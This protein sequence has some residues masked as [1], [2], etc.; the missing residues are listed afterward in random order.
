MTTAHKDLPALPEGWP[1]NEMINAGFNAGMIGSI[2]S[3][4]KAM[5][6]AAPTIGTVELADCGTCGAQVSVPVNYFAALARQEPASKTYGP[7]NPPRLRA[8]GESVRDYRVSMGW[9]EWERASVPTVEI[10]VVDMLLEIARLAY[11]A[12]DGTEENDNGLQWARGDFEALSSAMDKLEQLP[13]DQPGIVM[14][15]AAKAAWALRKTAQAAPQGQQSAG[16]GDE[17]CAICGL[18]CSPGNCVFGPEDDPAQEAGALSGHEQGIVADLEAMAKK[19]D[20]GFWPQALAI[21]ALVIIK[22]KTTPAQPAVD[23]VAAIHN[24]IL[25]RVYTP[26]TGYQEAFIQGHHRGYDTAR[27]DFANLVAAHLKAGE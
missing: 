15:P 2:A 4:F 14:G 19:A 8:P 20:N 5:L 25:E 7:D 22:R 26:I 1:T 3:G 13:D 10:L 24:A 16:A 23:L 18:P 11:D 21:G 6:L 17:H 27:L 12:M 9:D